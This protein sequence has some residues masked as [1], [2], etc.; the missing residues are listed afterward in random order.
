MADPICMS[1]DTVMLVV[2]V[3]FTVRVWR[4]YRRG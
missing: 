2:V 1:I 3:G 4:A